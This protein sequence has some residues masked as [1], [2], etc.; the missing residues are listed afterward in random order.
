M[1]LP[2]GDEVETSHRSNVRQEASR[3]WVMGDLT[4]V[5]AVGRDLILQLPRQITQALGG[6]PASSPVF[7]G[8]TEDFDR[9][10]TALDPESLGAQGLVHAVTG[11]PGV[12]KTELILQVAA[13]AVAREG[14]FPGGVLFVDLGGYSA[15]RRVTPELALAGFLRALGLPAEHMPP[16]LQ[17]KARLYASILG[18]YA[19]ASRRLLVVVDNAASAEDVKPLL[20]SD[21]RT[22]ILVTSRHSLASLGARLHSLS[23]LNDQG[24]VA[25][26]QG[27][28]DATA[29]QSDTRVTD[30]PEQAAAI[31]QLCGQLPLALHIVAALLADQPTKPL[32]A[33]V[34]DLASAKEELLDELQH[35]NLA[36][37]AAFDLSY[38]RLDE[39]QSLLFRLLTFNPGPD[40]STQ[41]AT[42]LLDRRESVTRRT[43]ESLQRAHLIEHGSEYGRWRMHD[44]MLLYAGECADAERDRDRS[45]EV[46]QRLLNFYT[47]RVKEAHARTE[48]EEPPTDCF[49]GRQEAIQ[50]LEAERLNLLAILSQACD[51]EHW[52]YVFPLARRLSGFLNKHRYLDDWCFVAAA[53]ARA[54]TYLGEPWLREAVLNLGEALTT[55]SR[56]DEGLECLERSMEL[57]IKASDT[58]GQGRTMNVIGV[59]RMELGQLEEASNLF[60]QAAEIFVAQD[61]KSAHALTRMNQGVCLAKQHRNDEAAEVLRDSA[62]F[63]KDIGDVRGETTSLANLTTLLPETSATDE[64]IEIYQRAVTVF[65]QDNDLFHEASARLQLGKAL[66]RAN[67]NQKEAV[68]ILKQAFSNFH[69]IRD[70]SMMA[71]TIGALGDCHSAAGKHRKALE[72]YEDAEEKFAEL[73][74][75]GARGRMSLSIALSLGAMGRHG[76]AIEAYRRA[77][78]FLRASGDHVREAAAWLGSASELHPIGR[79][80]DAIEAIHQAAIALDAD[81][82]QEGILQTI[83]SLFGDIL[84]AARSALDS[85]SIHQEALRLYEPLGRVE[86]KAKILLSLGIVHQER[87]RLREAELKFIESAD[88]FSSAQDRH[89]TAVA[90]NNLAAC[91][92]SQEKFESAITACEKALMLY[93]EDEDRNGEA[94]TLCNQGVTLRGLG[95]FKEAVETMTRAVDIFRELRNKKQVDMVSNNLGCVYEDLGEMEKAESLWRSAARGGSASAH[96]NLTR[97][98]GKK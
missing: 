16:D 47:D 13:H 68:Q 55:A 48:N 66:T 83:L 81:D 63:F 1:T 11:M 28:L 30:E 93:R 20:P 90:A 12:G 4:Q 57:N 64:A 58:F 21:K 24:A 50:W 33:M 46:A 15:D 23:A 32:A 96:A 26:L 85:E 59:V 62:N 86:F 10:V 5:G 51:S 80:R 76:D 3:N 87:G 77:A 92:G 91:L 35:E 95:R 7:E 74:D 69:S 60:H 9:I 41:A 34:H 98:R 61:A 97:V 25:L 29:R 88:L 40:F 42:A 36:V 65:A 14:W 37:R 39:E 8:R 44:L 75:I 72:S 27:A 22:P 84:K 43:L 94:E 19:E 45:N 79:L 73:N 70:A 78:E 2:H 54:A 82:S 49:A 56:Y 17:T 53:A 71:E 52:S 38:R 67:K 6:I 89:F 18:A 31:A